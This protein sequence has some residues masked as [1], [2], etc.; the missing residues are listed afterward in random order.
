MTML[1]EVTIVPAVMEGQGRL[2]QARE[3]SGRRRCFGDSVFGEGGAEYR[4][5]FR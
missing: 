1:D 2:Q 3:D 5:R 4:A